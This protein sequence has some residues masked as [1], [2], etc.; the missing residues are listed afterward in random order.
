M[1]PPWKI[2][3]YRGQRWHN[4]VAD[5]T[6]WHDRAE[7]VTFSRGLAKRIKYHMEQLPMV[8]RA[9]IRELGGNRLGTI[10]VLV[11]FTGSEA[12]NTSEKCMEMLRVYMILFENLRR[13]KRMLAKGRAYIPELHGYRE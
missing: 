13:Q 4:G 5:K 3:P 1:P 8:R 11:E 9:V 12:C 7:V 6:T 10:C 2:A